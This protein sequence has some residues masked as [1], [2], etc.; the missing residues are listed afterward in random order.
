[1]RHL[2]GLVQARIVFERWPL[3]TRGECHPRARTIVVNLAALDAAEAAGGAAARAS[4]L[5]AIIAHELAHLLWYDVD[6]NVGGLPA[7]GGAE[8][9]WAHAFAARLAPPR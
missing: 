2:A 9:S 3:V 8:E 1:M 6:R 5:D 7:S 4:M